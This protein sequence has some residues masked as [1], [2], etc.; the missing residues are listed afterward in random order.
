MA[1]FF[2]YQSAA[3]DNPI[4]TNGPFYPSDWLHLKQARCSSQRNEHSVHV[5]SSASQAFPPAISIPI[6]SQ[7]SH[8]HT[9]GQE[10]TSTLT[11]LEEQGGHWDEQEHEEERQATMSPYHREHKE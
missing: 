1:I 2:S 9:R 5:M 8:C 3:V 7:G 6:P 4:N 10:G 11:D